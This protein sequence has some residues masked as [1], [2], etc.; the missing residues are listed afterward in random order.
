MLLLAASAN[1]WVNV[2]LVPVLWRL[3]MSAF[4]GATGC[5]VSKHIWLADRRRFSLRVYS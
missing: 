5:H 2:C 4:S 3:M 1:A